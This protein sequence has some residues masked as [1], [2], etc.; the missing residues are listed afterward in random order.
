[1]VIDNYKQVRIG[2][3]RPFAFRVARRNIGPTW[4]DRTN[5]ETS[6]QQQPAFLPVSVR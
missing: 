3:K 2:A 1:M 4:S 5:T 6:D